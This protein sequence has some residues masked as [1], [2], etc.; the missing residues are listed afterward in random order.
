M[1][2]QHIHLTVDDNDLIGFLYAKG[3]KLIFEFPY[4]IRYEVVAMK[5]GRD[6]YHRIQLFDIDKDEAW[7]TAVRHVDDCVE[8]WEACNGAN[9][10][11]AY[12]QYSLDN[13]PIQA[14]MRVVQA[15]R[16]TLCSP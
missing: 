13:N 3:D 11:H 9:H 7:A 4:N 14:L 6:G 10:A 8:P 2:K 5:K 12:Y 15:S 16:G 1:N